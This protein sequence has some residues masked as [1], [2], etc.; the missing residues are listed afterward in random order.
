LRARLPVVAVTIADIAGI[1][2]D[3]VHDCS[4]RREEYSAA[5][6]RIRTTLAR[7]LRE[8]TD[9]EMDPF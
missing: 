4:G 1:P 7:S 5:R 6:L 2:N 8:V 3:A 9:G